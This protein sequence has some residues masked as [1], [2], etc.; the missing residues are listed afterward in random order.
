MKDEG[1][2]SKYGSSVKF[3]TIFALL[4]LAYKGMF[5]FIWRNDVLFSLYYDFSLRF[6]NGLLLCSDY[7]LTVLGYSV[8][9][10]E[11]TRI[12]KIGATSGVTVGEPCIGFDIMALFIGLIISTNLKLNIKFTMQQLRYLL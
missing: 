5:F 11:V 7:L 9:T 1:F 12:V 3:I 8:E 10:V 6:I 2:W 4:F